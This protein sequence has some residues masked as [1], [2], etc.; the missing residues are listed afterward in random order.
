[1]EQQTHGYNTGY[2]KLHNY[3]SCDKNLTS[4]MFGSKLFY[5]NDD[6]D[7]KRKLLILPQF[8]SKLSIYVFVVRNNNNNNI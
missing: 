3:F 2:F 7:D 5:D 1:M 8:N 6:D 4:I